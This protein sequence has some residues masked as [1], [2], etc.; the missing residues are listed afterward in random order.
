MSQ[1]QF[2]VDFS[3]LDPERFSFL[4]GSIT[5]WIWTALDPWIASEI[6]SSLNLAFTY[7]MILL[8]DSVIIKS[9]LAWRNIYAKFMDSTV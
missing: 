5:E 1:F 7:L 2:Y 9:P 3:G 8:I 4:I 6:G